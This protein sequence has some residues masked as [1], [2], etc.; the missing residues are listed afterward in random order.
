MG[1][2]VKASIAIDGSKFKAVN[3]RDRN[4]TRATAERHRV[5]LE[6]SVTRYLCQLDTAD[7]REPSE[8]AKTRRLKVELAKLA[9]EMQ[10]LDGRRT[11][12]KC[13]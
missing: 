10:R 3:N 1:L 11:S 13:A 9:E 7:R 2:L 12:R 4:Y 5:R 8:A 6:Q